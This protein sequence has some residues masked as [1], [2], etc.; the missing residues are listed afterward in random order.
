MRQSHIMIALLISLFLFM[1]EAFAADPVAVILRDRGKVDIFRKDVATS[2]D[3]RKGMVLYDGDKIVT[4]ASSICMI[5]YTDDKSLLRIKANSSC[6]IE[7]KKEAD[8]VDKNI[9]VQFGTFFVDLFRPKG[10]FTVTTPTSVASVKGT[11]WWVIQESPTKYIVVEGMID[12][13]NKAG[14]FL[15]KAGQTAIFTSDSE[16]PLIALTKEGEIPA[17]ED[18]VGDRQS[19]EIEFKDADGKTKKMIIDYQ[20]NEE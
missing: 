6:V 13:E 5:K 7:G 1:A 10:K 17:L 16:A 9:V 12:C 11:K 2:Q 8:K 19:L 4:S 3:A 18:E 20:K 14:K 15:V